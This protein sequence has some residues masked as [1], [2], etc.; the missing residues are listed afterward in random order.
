MVEV[1]IKYAFPLFTKHN[2]TDYLIKHDQI[3]VSDLWAFW[4]YIIGRYVKKYAGEKDFLLALIEQ[5]RYFYEAA[6]KAPIK[7]Q[8]LLYYYSFLNLVKVVINVNALSSYGAGYTYYH[9]VESCEIK[10][11]DKL[12]DLFVVIKSLLLPPGKTPKT[13]KLPDLSVAYTFMIQMGDNVPCPPPY[14]L[15][16]VDM[17]KACI[18][19]HR[20]YCETNNEREIFIKLGDPQ[21]YREGKILSCKYEVKKCDATILAQLTAAG[22]NIVQEIDVNGIVHYN[23]I[24]K[25]TMSSYKETKYD[26]FMLAKLLRE[27]GIWY[28]TDGSRYRTFIST[29]PLHISTESII[30]ILMF[31]FGSITRYHPYMF[32]KLLT[33]QQMWLISEFLKT[34]PKQFLHTVTSRTIESAVLKP[35]TAN[36]IF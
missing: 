3:R 35:N 8:P 34:Q 20:T 1:P 12:Q 33:E 13:G 5:A 9:G 25:R 27:K 17:L 36:I 19:I 6:E 29:S 28:F 32:D 10:K 26:Y 7:S 14:K 16:I 31:F 4:Q 24:E 15:N 2:S 30:Y 11:R 23:W 18:G 22:Y 21:L